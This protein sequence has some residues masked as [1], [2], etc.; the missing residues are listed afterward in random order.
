MSAN[1]R[2]FDVRTKNVFWGKSSYSNFVGQVIQLFRT[3]TFQTVQTF[4]PP[5]PCPIRK[6]STVCEIKHRSNTEQYIFLK[7]QTW[8]IWYYTYCGCSKE[9]LSSYP[10]KSWWIQRCHYISQGFSSFDAFFWKFWKF[11][12]NSGKRFWRHFISGKNR[13]FMKY[14]QKQYICCTFNFRNISLTD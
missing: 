9:I 7:F 14:L 1:I 3:E 4:L 10:D 6:F 12:S 5:I 2:S 11:V 8:N 13:E